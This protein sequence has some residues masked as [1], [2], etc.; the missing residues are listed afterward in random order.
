MVILDKISGKFSKVII[1]MSAFIFILIVIGV[2]YMVDKYNKEEADRLKVQQ[3][4]QQ[5]KNQRDR[6]ITAM[7]SISQT[8]GIQDVEGLFD[9]L[10]GDK[11]KLQSLGWKMQEFSCTGFFCNIKFSKIDGAFFE[12][13]DIVKKGEVHTPMFNENE[14]V[15]ENLPYDYIESTNDSPFKYQSCTD[16]ISSMYEFKSIFNNRIINDLTVSEPVPVFNFN[17]IYD[18][19]DMKDLKYIDASVKFDNVITINLLNDFY[20]EEEVYFNFFSAKE[21]SFDLGLKIYCM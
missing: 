15:F 21:N 20:T 11:Q 12:Y 8:P 2:I 7:D 19:A 17:K 13:V 14:L 10:E 5:E 16:A 4:V 3:Q 9:E 1:A 18:W 6:Y